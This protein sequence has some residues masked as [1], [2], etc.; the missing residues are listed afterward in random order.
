MGEKY[1]SPYQDFPF[2]M[3]EVGKSAVAEWGGTCGC[4]IGAGAALALFWGRKERDP[5]LNE[6]FRWYEVTALPLFQPAPGTA[7]IDKSMPTS[8]SESIL[9]HI[10]VTKWCTAN[11]I[12]SASPERSERCARITADIAVKT[13]Q[14]MQDKMDGTFKATLAKSEGYETCTTEGCHG[15]KKDA[16]EQPYLKGQMT[17]DPCHTGRK[18]M[19]DKRKE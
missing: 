10:S 5:L 15:G 1:G 2:S 19:Q 16:F 12:P 17:C 6:L 11:K 3:M 13:A 7:K 9:C 8:V 14:I 18:A 4:L